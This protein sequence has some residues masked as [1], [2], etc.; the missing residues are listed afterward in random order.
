MTS[1]IINPSVLVVFSVIHHLEN[2]DDPSDEVHSTDQTETI[3]AHVET[4]AVP[5]QVRR[6]E[7]LSELTKVLPLSVYRE[8]VPI[9][10]GIL[11]GLGVG[12]LGL[13]KLF[14]A[15]PCEYSHFRS[16]GQE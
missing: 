6:A 15:T 2:I 14:E 4:R 8:L 1:T 12:L 11:G 16:I 7:C 9:R 13:P 10:Q 3:V 5:D